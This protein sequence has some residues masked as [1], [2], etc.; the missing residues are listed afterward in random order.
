M[1]MDPHSPPRTPVPTWLP[2]DWDIPF[3]YSTSGPTIM[4]YHGVDTIY[5]FQR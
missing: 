4:K 3:T 1:L 2:A 5:D